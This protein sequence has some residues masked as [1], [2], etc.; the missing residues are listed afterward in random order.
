M[1]AVV[2][3]RDLLA[4]VTDRAKGIT[5][6]TGYVGQISAMAGLPGVD[7]PADPPLK[8]DGTRRVRPYFVIFPGIGGPG[9]EDRLDDAVHD[10]AWPLQIN[11]VA[12][13]VNDLLALVDRVT[14]RFHRWSPGVLA[15]PHGPVVVGP[16]RVPDGYVPQQLT[17]EIDGQPDRLYVPLQYRATAHT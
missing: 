6:A 3:L 5:N 9:D 12:G 11:A 16:F 1:P 10:L 8:T 7:T 15:G 17:D 2:A 14:D 13:D 4:V